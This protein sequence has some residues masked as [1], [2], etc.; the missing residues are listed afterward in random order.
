MRKFEYISIG[1]PIYNAEA[2]LADAIKSVLAQTHPYW[3]LILVDDGSTDNS[4]KIAQSFAQKDQRI[5][6]ISDGQ[7]KK[8][9]S[10]LNQLVHEARYEFIARM[11]ADDLISPTRLERQLDFLQKNQKCDLVSTGVLSLKNDLSLMGV[12][13]TNMDKRNTLEDAVM[14]TTGIIHAS[15]VARKSWF[16]RNKYNENNRL[17]EDYELWLKA[18]LNHDLN[19]GFI[20][21][22]LYYYR[23]D[24]N[25]RLDKLLRA[26]S[27]QIEIISSLKESQLSSSLRKAFIRKFLVKKVIVRFLFLMKLDF[28]L[29]KRRVD[30]SRNSEFLPI[31]QHNL[32]VIKSITIY[33]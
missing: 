27:S 18:F 8:L 22:P 9:P 5:R 24:Q 21:E 29:H 2:Y 23:E 32:A 26:Y 19:V 11:D 3:E 31:L 16:L 7:N 4:L 10:R 14:G 20:E 1:I 12:R 17:A 13:T 15:V 6:V 25:I 28:I 33:Q 30:M